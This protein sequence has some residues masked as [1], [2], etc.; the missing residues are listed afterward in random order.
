MSVFDAFDERAAWFDEHY[1]SVRGRI[2]LALL[3]ERLD[4]L[5]PPAPA[6]ILDAGGGSGV[7]AVSLAERGYDVTVLDASSSMIA[8]ARDHATE[9]GVALTTVQ[10][11]VEEVARLAPGPFDAVCLHA[12][13]LYVEDP[14]SVLKAMR[15][16]VRDGAALSLLEKNRDGLSM[17]PGLR[18]DYA[19]AIRVLDDPVAAGNLGIANRSR[20]VEEW[21]ALLE[22]TGWAVDGWVGIRLFSD[23][24]SDDLG[25]E[26]F[27]QL[28]ALERE[29]GR[30]PSYRSVARLIHLAARAV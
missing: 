11:S 16:A 1:G 23:A 29:A 13:L 2:R 20:S 12:L 22:S 18:G 28:L 4:E 3:L 21:A 14:G 15:S 27:E 19:E 30:R 6:R 17:R 5:L 9:H 25:D 8:I 24:A 26:R 7:V 10:G